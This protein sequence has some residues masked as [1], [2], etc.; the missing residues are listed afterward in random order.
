MIQKFNKIIKVD[1]EI[2]LPGDKSISHRALIFAA[3]AEGISTIDNISDGMDVKSTINCLNQL[4]VSILIE[5]KFAKVFG[6]GFK[7]F[8]APVTSL[9]CGNSGTT[10]RLLSG[11]LAAQNFRCKLIGDESLSKRPMKRVIEPL[12]MM[13][14]D[15]SSVSDFTLPIHIKAPNNL[16]SIRYELTVPSAQVKSAVL[17]AGLHN[18]EE[19]SV[20]ESVLTRDHTERMLGLDVL[21][22]KNKITSKASIKNYPLQKNYFVPGDISTASFLVV[23]TLIS[24]NSKLIIKNVSLNPTRTAV[25]TQL[26]KMGAKI[27]ITNT[28]MNSNEKYGDLIISSSQLHNMNIDESIIPLL[29]DEIPI[30][31][32]AGVFAAGPFEVRNCR[33]LR[34][35]ESDRIRALCHNFRIAGL[36]VDEY[37]DGFSISGELSN[38]EFLFD[39]FGDHRIAMSFAVFSMLNKKGGAVEGFESVAISN[40]HFLTQ[41]SELVR[42]S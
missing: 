13:G 37:E 40:P 19:T 27:G 2:D 4:G 42:F 33:E 39:S 29:I 16:K 21:I 9:N 10:A 6:V 22:E 25:L 18:E 38:R 5:K 34:F 23:L 11:L 12:R 24:R 7:N 3:M 20:I 30:L 8:K 35:K 26:I 14:A 32:V 36:N 41:V 31:A 1:G 15:I 28:K 17:I